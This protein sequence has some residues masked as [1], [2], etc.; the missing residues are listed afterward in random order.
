[1]IGRPAH[2]VSEEEALEYVAGYTIANDLTD[3]GTVFRRDMPQ[4]GTDRLRSENAP[5]SHRSAPGSCPPRRSRTPATCA[6]Y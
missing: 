4:I 6:S 2:Q 3:R 5:G 1:M